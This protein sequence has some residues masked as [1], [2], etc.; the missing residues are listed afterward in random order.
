[1][2]NDIRQKLLDIISWV[3]DIS[4]SL[5]IDL[6]ESTRNKFD[7]YAE[8][9][10]IPVGPIPVDKRIKA[11]SLFSNVGIGEYFLEDTLVDIKV[12]NELLKDRSDLYKSIYPE[13]KMIHGDIAEVYKG[14]IWASR[15]NN[16]KMVIAT[17]PC[18][19]FSIAGKMDENDPRNTLIIHVIN[20]ILD[21]DCDYALIENVPN[22]VKSY[23]S[24]DGEKRKIDD[25][26]RD[27]LSE[28]NV[29][30]KVIN[31][32]DYGVPQ[33]RKRGIYLISK[34]GKWEFPN[35]KKPHATVRETIGHLPSLESEEKTNIKWHNAKKHNENHIL[36]M[37]N[38]PS[39]KSAYN[40]LDKNINEYY[41]QTKGR[42]IKGFRTTYKRISWDKPAPTI[43]MSNGAISSQNNVHPGHKNID[44]TYSDA[45]VLTLLEIMLLTGIPE[46]WRIPEDTKENLIRKVIGEAVPPLIFLKL[47]QNIKIA[48]PST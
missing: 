48:S 33:T 24:I 6:S 47:I 41:P 13:V 45:R 29:E 9:F 38:T 32:A 21:L 7:Y 40:N 1:M 28:Y 2:D 27:R 5:N 31:T 43:T 23:I 37:K 19:G 3:N 46:D 25:Y 18:Q 44:G 26:I 15:A 36:W 34:K 22:M 30:F 14:V 8:D 42:D 39:G 11:L 20:S 35:I 4:D 17:P 12:A 10:N 16:C